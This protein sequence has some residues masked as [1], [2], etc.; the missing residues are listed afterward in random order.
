[1]REIHPPPSLFR[2]LSESPSLIP[3]MKWFFF[4]SAFALNHVQCAETD[5]IIDWGNVDVNRSR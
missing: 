5:I 3:N 1:M 2:S 4:V